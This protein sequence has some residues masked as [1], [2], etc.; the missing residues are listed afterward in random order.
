[1]GIETSSRWTGVS[2][3][4]DG[5][6]HHNIVHNHEESDSQIWLH[7]CDTPCRAANLQIRKSVITRLKISNFGYKS[8]ISYAAL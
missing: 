3:S 4:E 2:V 7:V 5:I 6:D 8:V 1:M